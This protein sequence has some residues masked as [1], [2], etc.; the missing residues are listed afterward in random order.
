MNQEKPK[1][2]L[3][4]RILGTILIIAG[5]LLFLAP[6]TI[7]VWGAIENWSTPCEERLKARLERNAG[8]TTN[9]DRDKL[10]KEVKSLCDAIRQKSLTSLLSF[11]FL[12]FSGLVLTAFGVFV[13]KR[14]PI[15]KEKA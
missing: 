4:V 15:E 11:G 5:F 13:I 12:A 6:T 9:I 14:K 3:L 1:K 7:L 8:S 10:D 2:R